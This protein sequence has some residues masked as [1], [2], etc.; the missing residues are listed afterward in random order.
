MNLIYDMCKNMKDILLIFL[1]SAT[2]GVSRSIFIGDIELI[3]YP[4]EGLSNQELVEAKFDGPRVINIDQCKRMFDSK[5]ALFIDARDSLLFEDGHIFGAINI[6]FES[7][8]D[9]AILEKLDIV[10]NDDFLIIY[11]SGDDCDLSE[12]LG[13]HLFEYLLYSNILLYEG[14]FPEWK[15]NEYP[16]TYR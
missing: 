11:C 2:V 10:S 16:I 13:N 12:E 7:N 8:N 6:H 3:K 5:S 9:D 15:D 14:G 4:V 1:V